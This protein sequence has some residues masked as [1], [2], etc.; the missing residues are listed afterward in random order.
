MPQPATLAVEAANLTLGLTPKLTIEGV[1]GR[2]YT[3]QYTTNLAEPI[4]WQTVTNVTLTQSVQIWYDYATDA[5]APNQPKR[6]Y[7]V[8]TAP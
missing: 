7:Q 3:I 4:Q 6:Y 5:T 8:I 1:G 2:T